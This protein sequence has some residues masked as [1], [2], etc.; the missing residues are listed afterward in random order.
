M[1]SAASWRQSSTDHRRV[2]RIMIAE[3][4]IIERLFNWRHGKIKFPTLLN[5]NSLSGDLLAPPIDRRRVNYLVRYFSDRFSG[6]VP[7]PPD[8]SAFALDS[9]MQFQVRDRD[10]TAQKK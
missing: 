1:P 8:R 5:G 10:D 3:L 9:E 6:N 2:L 7:Q 4:I